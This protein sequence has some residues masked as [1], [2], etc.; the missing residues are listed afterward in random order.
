M[1]TGKI[2]QIAIIDIAERTFSAFFI[3]FINSFSSPIVSASTF[4]IIS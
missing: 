4:N 3:I 2:N 1:K